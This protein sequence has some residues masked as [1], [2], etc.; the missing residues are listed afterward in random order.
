MNQRMSPMALP[1][2]RVSWICTW[3]QKLLSG[4]MY[5]AKADKLGQSQSW[6]PSQAGDAGGKK[7]QDFSQVAIS[8]ILIFDGRCCVS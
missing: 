1:K 8:L 6:Q 4:L 7:Q 3:F 5:V 2:P